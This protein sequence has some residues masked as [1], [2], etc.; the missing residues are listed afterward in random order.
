MAWE[1][2]GWET[3]DKPQCGQQGPEA[4]KAPPWKVTE[5]GPCPHLPRPVPKQV[6]L[7]AE[8]PRV[9]VGKMPSSN[10]FNLKKL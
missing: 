7:P 9:C 8:L 2:P 5:A 4:E 3:E 6:T 1:P 10:P